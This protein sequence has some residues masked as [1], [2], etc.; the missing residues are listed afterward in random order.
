MSIYK[1][2]ALPVAMLFSI[3]VQAEGGSDRVKEW[4]EQFRESQGLIKVEILENETETPS[5]QH[6][7][8]D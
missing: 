2:A 5:T 6:D 3:G 8:T 1:L 7:K 4:Q